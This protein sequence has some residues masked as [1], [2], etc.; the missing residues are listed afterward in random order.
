MGRGVRTAAMRVRFSLL[1]RIAP[2]M[3]TGCNPLRGILPVAAA[4]FAFPA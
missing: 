3:R 4:L 1:A 2:A